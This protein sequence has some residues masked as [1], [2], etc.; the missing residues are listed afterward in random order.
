[1]NNL[2]NEATDH[3]KGFYLDYTNEP[4]KPQFIDGT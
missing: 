4:A 2:N 3:I 1:M